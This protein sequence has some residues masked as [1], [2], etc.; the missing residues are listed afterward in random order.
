M[1]GTFSMARAAS[2]GWS[3]VFTWGRQGLTALKRS[4]G[5]VTIYLMYIVPQSPPGQAVH[6]SW[7]V[8]GLALCQGRYT[9]HFTSSEVELG[10][11]FLLGMRACAS[12]CARIY[13][14]LCLF[15]FL[16]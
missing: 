11:S 16:G 1:S 6:Q 4:R 8:L 7:S 15:Y 2:W 10:V 3:R 13:I 5:Y 14:S 9:R 12:L